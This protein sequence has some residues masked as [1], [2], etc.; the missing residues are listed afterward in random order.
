MAARHLLRNC[1]PL[2]MGILSLTPL[3]AGDVSYRIPAPKQKWFT[4]ESANFQFLTDCSERRTRDLAQNFE[5]IRHVLSQVTPGLRSGRYSLQATVPTYVYLFDD[6][7]DFDGYAGSTGWAGFFR[8]SPHANFVAVLA[9]RENAQMIVYHEYIHYF[10]GNNFPGTPSWANEGL[11]EYF[12]SISLNGLDVVIGRPIH[13]H[14]LTLQNKPPL[15][16]A[17]LTGQRMNL[18]DQSDE[19]V[20]AHYYASAWLAVHYLLVGSEERKHQLGIFLELIRTGLPAEEGFR[21]AFKCEPAGMDQELLGYRSRILNRYQA[22]MVSLESLAMVD[23][24]VYTPLPRP[25]AL[26]RLGM[27]ASSSNRT[28]DF[29]QA[30][31]AAALAEHPA[32]G[33]AH[34]GRAYLALSGQQ[35]NDAAAELE[36]VV[37]AHP[38]DPQGRYLAGLAHIRAASVDGPGTHGPDMDAH[39]R[40]ALDH[41][42]RCLELEAGHVQALELLLSLGI[43]TPAEAKGMA[44]LVEKSVLLL[45]SRLDLQSRLADLLERAG[46]ESRCKAIWESLASQATRPELADQAKLRLGE[47]VDRAAQ[48]TFMEGQKALDSGD[49][50]EGRRLVGVA[51][52]QAASP[53]LKDHFESYL[54]KRSQKPVLTLTGGKKGPAKKPGS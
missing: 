3:Q 54:I 18:H 12:S 21:R 19:S 35:W 49:E 26:G 47:L 48:A 8:G 2:V 34:L 17:Q 23:R 7:R 31:C 53:A 36:R 30:L 40:R 38:L 45:P 5:V 37:E 22:M 13:H 4:A 39:H 24:F 32:S 41:L 27:L 28:R 33:S 29:A 46:E 52:Q 44:G 51:I 9:E 6:V 50:A 10:V 42:Q 1:C 15:P 25:E 16:M 14:L 43:S 20:R 11:A